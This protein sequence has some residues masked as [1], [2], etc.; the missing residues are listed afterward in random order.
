MSLT[1]APKAIKPETLRSWLFIDGADDAAL[2]AGPASGADVLIQEL[3]DFTPPEKRPH[4]REIS[5]EIISAWKA[6]GI[7]AAV[8]INPLEGDGAADLAA[9]MIG[10]PD[11]VMLPKAAGPAQITALAAAM[12]QLEADCDVPPGAT[13]IVPNIEQASGLMQTHAICRSNERIAG[14][15]VAS[16]DMAADLGAE[17]GPD[18]IE[19]AYVRERFHLECVAAGVLSIDCPYTWTDTE[20]LEADTLHARRLGYTAKSAVHPDHPRVINRLLTPTGE[21]VA[22]A[23]RIVAAFEAARAGGQA[24][25]EL[26]GSLVEVP[27]YLNAKRLLARAEL[28]NETRL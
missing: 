1:D 15:I 12:S 22:Q 11:I 13:L 8:R 4:A 9:I 21:D 24:R 26:D 6:E 20:G 27:I 25:A 23:R 7:V 14:C 5:P 17:R 16:E 18:G 10:R 2:A 3:E 28:L 19:L